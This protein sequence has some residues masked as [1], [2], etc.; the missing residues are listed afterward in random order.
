MYDVTTS[1][2]PGPTNG[3]PP[4]TTP[5]LKV[6]RP[7]KNTHWMNEM[8]SDTTDFAPGAATWRTLRNIR[9]VFDSGLFGQLYVNKRD[10]INKTGST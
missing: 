10:A 6:G 2:N 8:Q 3:P 4:H 5:K 7:N 1:V 9:V